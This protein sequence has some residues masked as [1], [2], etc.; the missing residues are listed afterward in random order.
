[1]TLKI[2]TSRYNYQGVG[3]KK[4]ILTATVEHEVEFDINDMLTIIGD[5]NSEMIYKVINTLG[6]NSD[7]V[8]MSYACK[9][10]TDKGVDFIKTMYYFL[11]KIGRIEDV[12]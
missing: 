6:E 3:D 7:E 8:D 1:M 5:S 11:T 9:D 4:L 2:E 12:I 10:L